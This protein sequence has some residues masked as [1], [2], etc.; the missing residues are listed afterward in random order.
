MLKTQDN[1]ATFYDINI[2]KHSYNLIFNKPSEYLMYFPTLRDIKIVSS[3]MQFCWL[4]WLQYIF[5]YSGFWFISYPKKLLIN[6]TL[7]TVSLWLM[8]LVAS[9]DILCG[10]IGLKC[11]IS[12]YA[13]VFNFSK[14]YKTEKI[15]F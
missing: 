3:D 5:M 11:F 8:C 13:A 4:S 15:G 14:L 9:Y 12:I 6:W 2:N 7:E 10:I 1:I